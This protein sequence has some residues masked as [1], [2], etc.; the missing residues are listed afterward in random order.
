MS[1]EGRT[2]THISN[3]H[4]SNRVD[5]GCWGG[6]A[7]YD[8]GPFVR[9]FEVSG[10]ELERRCQLPCAKKRLDFGLSSRDGRAMSFHC[11]LAAAVFDPHCEIWRVMDEWMGLVVVNILSVSDAVMQSLN[12][13]I[14]H[15]LLWSMR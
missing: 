6:I 8:G 15:W 4:D 9:Q 1:R 3:L 13:G 2:Q 12:T 10:A 7:V 14:I 5:V 11:Y